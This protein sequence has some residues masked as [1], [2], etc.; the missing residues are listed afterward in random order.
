MRVLEMLVLVKESW[1]LLLGEGL[2]SD[3]GDFSEGGVGLENPKGANFVQDVLVKDPTDAK[4][5][6]NI[7]SVIIFNLGFF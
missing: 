1:L 5:G 2:A 7:E 4:G 6:G 3:R